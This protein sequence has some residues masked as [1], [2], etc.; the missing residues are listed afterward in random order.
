MTFLGGP[1]KPSLI[2]QLG[3]QVPER[4]CWMETW[5]H[6]T[7]VICH[8]KPPLVSQL[9]ARLTYPLEAAQEAPGQLGDGGKSAQNGQWHLPDCHRHYTR[10]APKLCVLPALKAFI[11][12]QHHAPLSL[13]AQRHYLWQSVIYRS[14]SEMLLKQQPGVTG[15][16]SCT[17]EH[18][19]SRPSRML[20]AMQ[21]GGPPACQ[22]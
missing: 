6:P 5:T 12:S 8:S 18:N 19:C 1:G 14:S 7:A 2:F 4:Q 22:Q 20:P 10:R 11:I 13:G 16:A 17:T 21:R 15:A 3:N 9:A